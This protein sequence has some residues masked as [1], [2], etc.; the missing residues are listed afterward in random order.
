MP[1]LALLGVVVAGYLATG[2]VNVLLTRL[3]GSQWSYVIL[4]AFFGSLLLWLGVHGAGALLDS[5]G[6][7]LLT[8]ALLLA[9]MV[10]SPLNY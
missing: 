4:L 6:A 3:L 10:A 5:V 8:A 9:L 1:A 2:A 7:A